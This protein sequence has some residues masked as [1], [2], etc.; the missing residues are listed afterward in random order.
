MWLCYSFVIQWGSFCTISSPF[1][2]LSTFWMIRCMDD[3]MISNPKSQSC[4][5]TSSQESVTAMSFFLLH[6]LLSVLSIYSHPPHSNQ[7]HEFQ[8][9]QKKDTCILA[10]FPFFLMWKLAQYW[11]SFCTWTL[12]FTSLN[13]VWK[14]LSTG[15]ETFFIHIYSDHSTPLCGHTIIYTTILLCMG[16]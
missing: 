6:S 16:T 9:I 14:S 8:F 13:I 3:C 15:S 7:P 10:Y 1:W 12:H 5:K 4:T 11:Y 2:V